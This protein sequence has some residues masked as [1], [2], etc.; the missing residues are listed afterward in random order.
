MLLTYCYKLQLRRN[1]HQL[2]DRLCEQQRLLYNAALQERIDAW[3]K[4]NISISK[5]DQFKS[6][7][8]IRSFDA[9]YAEVPVKMSRWTISRV[10]D[11]FTGFFGRVKRGERP[12][13]PR[14]KSILRWRSFGFQE[15]DGISLQDGKLVSRIFRRS[16]LKV[17]MH[18]KIPSD[19]R[20]RS[21]T[22]TR[23]G[24]Y[25][26]V[27]LAVAVSFDEKHR[28]ESRVVGLDLGV[29]TLV[30][31]SD[32]DLIAN[33]R[34]RSKREKA[35]RRAQRALARC[36]RGS[37]RRCKVR[38]RVARLHRRIANARATYLHQ[39]SERIARDHGFIA[40]EA[41]NVRNLT[42]SGKGAASV[43]GMNVRQKAGLNR[44]LFDAAPAKLIELISYKAERAGGILVTV[45]PRNTSQRCSACGAVVRKELSQRVHRCDC[46]A[47]LDRDVNAALNIL[48]RALEAHGRARPPGDGN[49]GHRPVRRLRNAV[50]AAA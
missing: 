37:K 19:S 49:V 5:L 7:T 31:T 14:F 28:Y 26:Y 20:I 12:G 50:G 3:R 42:R 24:R 46:G 35:L 16:G 47:I 41:L 18:R 25:W 38:E 44:S 13:F 4:A 22:F 2:M 45:D 34:P 29:T 21:C 8:Q 43:P 40:V 23:R 48:H 6:L 39:V 1:Q 33:V 27:S 10:D 11:A 32:G 17:R 15:F 9:V 30:A 36:Q